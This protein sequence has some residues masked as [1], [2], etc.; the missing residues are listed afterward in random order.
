MAL[1]TLASAGIIATL[2]PTEPLYGPAQGAPGS[3]AHAAPAAAGYR[4]DPEVAVQWHGMWA[5]YTDEQRETVLGQLRQS[6]IHGLRMDVSWA[7]L[8]PTSGTA[9]DPWGVGFLDRVIGMINSHG[10]TPLIT[11]W[12]TP[13]WANGNRGER[14]PPTNPA[15]YAKVA[16]W[17]A[18]RYAG[19]VGAWEVWNE[20]NSNDFFV[21]AN[22]VVYTRLLQAAYP[23]FKAGDPAAEVV[24]GGTQYNDDVWIGKCYD[25]G[26]RGYFDVMSTHS[27]Q[28][29]SNQSPLTPDDGTKYKFTHVVAV[30]NLMVARGDGN[31][32]IWT[33]MG[34]STHVDPPDTP[35]WFRGVSEVTQAIY[36]NQAVNLIRERWPWVG[37]FGWYTTRDEDQ[38]QNYHE[39]HYGL[40]RAD[41]SIKPALTALYDL[42]LPVAPA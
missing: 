11:L 23:A 27:Y 19:R 5:F 14:V 6:N 18:N 16:R 26:V 39:R 32:S 15:D 33:G 42:T 2:A 13:G 8:Q 25:A 31:K 9:F 30:R 34:Y 41:L 3:L 37:K 29:P 20:P 12:L 17:A 22:P 7:M 28:S 24:F 10:I 35:T 40:L 36:L 4:L 38:G 21:G 1:T